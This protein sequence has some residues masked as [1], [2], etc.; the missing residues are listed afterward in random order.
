MNKSQ[1]VE[2]VASGA[3]I[4]KADA[5]RAVDALLANIQIEVK[6]GQRVTIPGFG[7]FERRSRRA[8]TARNPRTGATIK[9][10]ATKVPAFKAGVGFKN[11]V[12]GKAPAPAAPK[13]AAKP[14][15]RPAAAKP[16]AR[17][18]AAKKAA[19]KKAAPKKA[20]APKKK[21]PARKPAAKK[22]AARKR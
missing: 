18:P 10:A 13:A 2:A 8:R 20:A 1:L 4:S 14:A 6:K 15:A 11:V 16:A 22:T 5:A 17:K 3:G 12:S 9:V 19:P 21:A 7:K